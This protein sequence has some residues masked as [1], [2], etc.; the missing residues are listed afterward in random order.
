MQQGT[1]FDIRPEMSSCAVRILGCLQHL[2]V[3]TSDGRLPHSF[4]TQPLSAAS[5]C[6]ACAF[7]EPV[8]VLARDDHE[9][10]DEA[11]V[12]HVEDELEDMGAGADISSRLVAEIHFPTLL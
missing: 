3:D 6:C 2:G 10:A 4:I 7:Q 9:S 5:A 1:I 11:R 12:K 8:L